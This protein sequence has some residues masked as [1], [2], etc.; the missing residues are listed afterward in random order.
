MCTNS[1]SWVNKRIEKF[2]RV[3][4]LKILL[5]TS[6]LCFHLTHFF[7]DEMEDTCAWF[8]TNEFPIFALKKY[9][10]LV[11]NE[12]DACLYPRIEVKTCSPS[13]VVNFFL[14][15]TKFVV[16][17]YFTLLRKQEMKSYFFSSLEDWKTGL[18]YCSTMKWI[19]EMVIGK[20][21]VL[22]SL[23]CVCI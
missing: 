16:D 14:K 9:Y 1:K 19:E 10:C 18:I 17:Y 20:R 5:N 22:E 7:S 4:S 12:E 2:Q 21:I 15:I 8:S 23:L 11:R 6:F 13:F 3:L